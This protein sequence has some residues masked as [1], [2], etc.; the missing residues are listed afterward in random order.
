MLV[1]SFFYEHVRVLCCLGPG[2]EC[3]GSCSASL[4]CASMYVIWFSTQLCDAVELSL[5]TGNAI[6]LV[7]LDHLCPYKYLVVVV[8]SGH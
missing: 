2:N 5:R 6:P 7:G 8:F 4:A 1:V 3:I